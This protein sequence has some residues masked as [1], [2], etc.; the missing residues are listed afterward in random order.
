MLN[1]KIGLFFIINNK[2][3][4]HTIPAETGEIRGGKFDNPYSHEQLFDDYFREGDYINF[5]RGRVVWDISENRAIIYI[6]RCVKEFA[7]Q[8][9]DRFNLTDYVIAYDEH[10]VCPN[11]MGDIWG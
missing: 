6:D 2:I 5:P 8:I 3:F 11:C 7:K 10:Y 4:S 1:T 9:A